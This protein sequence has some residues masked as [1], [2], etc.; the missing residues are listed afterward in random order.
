[1]NISSEQ[2]HTY[3]FTDTSLAY[4]PF[5]RTETGQILTNVC[6]NDRLLVFKLKLIVGQTNEIL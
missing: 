4:I 1:M 3:S 2:T 6:L 5:K